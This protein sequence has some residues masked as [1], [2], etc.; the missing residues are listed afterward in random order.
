MVPLWLQM[1]D[2]EAGHIAPVVFLPAFGA[3]KKTSK[4]SWVSG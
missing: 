2:Q 4:R 3:H 1:S